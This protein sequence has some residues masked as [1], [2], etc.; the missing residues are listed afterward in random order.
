[1]ALSQ[2]IGNNHSGNDNTFPEVM[3]RGVAKALS[4]TPYPVNSGTAEQLLPCNNH[5]IQH[6]RR[7][8]NSLVTAK[9]AYCGEAIQVVLDRPW[10]QRLGLVHKFVADSP[11]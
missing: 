9:S 7:F 4:A 1:M 10:E 3:H 11:S 8:T 5:V 6:Q 2:F